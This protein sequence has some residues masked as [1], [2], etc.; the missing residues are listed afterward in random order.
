MSTLYSIKTKGWSTSSLSTYTIAAVLT[1]ANEQLDA[2]TIQLRHG[3]F[4]SWPENPSLKHIAKE[5]S[6]QETT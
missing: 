5:V 3:T 4:M 2:L 6:T 1:S